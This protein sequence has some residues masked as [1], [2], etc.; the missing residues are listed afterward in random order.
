MYGSF[1]MRRLDANT[2]LF[3]IRDLGICRVW[4]SQGSWDQSPGEM[5]GGH[6]VCVH[7]HI[8]AL[9]L[10]KFLSAF[11][12]FLVK[13]YFP[14]SSAAVFHLACVISILNVF[15]FL[16][17]VIPLLWFCCGCLGVISTEFCFLKYSK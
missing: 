9:L 17:V 16:V 2:M 8:C 11:T 13:L 6:G 7:M 5:E 3:S 10:L 1:D 15:F 4:Y 14:C 12:A